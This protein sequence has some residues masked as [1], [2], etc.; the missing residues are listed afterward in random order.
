VTEVAYDPAPADREEEVV[1]LT[2]ACVAVQ[3]AAIRRN[4]AEWVWMH[5]RWKT[6]PPEPISGS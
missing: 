2:A 4:P 5:R 1:R 3:E 6:A